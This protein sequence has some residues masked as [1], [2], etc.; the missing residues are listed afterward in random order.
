MELQSE[1]KS[2]RHVFIMAVSRNQIVATQS[3]EKAPESRM[4][5]GYVWRMRGGRSS[6]TIPKIRNR[7]YF[8][9]SNLTDI[10]N[11]LAEIKQVRS[12]LVL[13]LCPAI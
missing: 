3:K 5:L 7:E 6:N 13:Q 11:V 8:P 9:S 4:Q 12:G 1:M 10:C 2:F